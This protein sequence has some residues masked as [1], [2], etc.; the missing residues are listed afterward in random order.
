MK[1]SQRL[2]MSALQEAYTQRMG[3]LSDY[4]NPVVQSG[5]KKK[6]GKKKH[7][8]QQKE[9]LAK[10]EENISLFQHLAERAKKENSLKNRYI[11]YMS[12]E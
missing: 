7:V 12:R 8:L 3:M 10:T 2:D 5:E 11:F 9:D 4:I 6:I 1:V